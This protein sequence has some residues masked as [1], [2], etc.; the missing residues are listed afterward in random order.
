M[1]WGA[2]AVPEKGALQNDKEERCT[3]SCSPAEGGLLIY[4]PNHSLMQI[5]QRL[6]HAKDWET[7][8]K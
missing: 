2:E 1:P 5:F 3:A 7:Q 4:S 8:N 6:L